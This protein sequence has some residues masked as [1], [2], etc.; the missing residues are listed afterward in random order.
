MTKETRVPEASPGM[1]SNELREFLIVHPMNPQ[2]LEARNVVKHFPPNVVAL[3]DGNLSVV[4]G[5][6]HCLLGANGAGKSTF[7]KIIAGAYRPDAGSLRLDGAPCIFR[8]PHEAPKA[9]IAIIY[10][11]LDLIP[12]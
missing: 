11:E 1:P 6:V 4:K 12:N 3:A 2:L 9:G 7:L 10:Q 5:E 8:S